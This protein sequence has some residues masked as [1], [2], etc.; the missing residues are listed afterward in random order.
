MIEFA[1]F[2]AGLTRIGSA[3]RQA[4]TP[5]D[6]E[7]YHIGMQHHADA[8]EWDRF[9]R[10]AIDPCRWTFFPKLRELQDALREF[11]G[12]RPMLAE[13]TNAYERVLAAGVYA[14]EGGTSWSYRSVRET[15]GD[16]AAEAF[17]AAGGHNA[18]AT[19]WEESKRRER[20][21]NAYADAVREEPD[22]KLLP[23]AP[24]RALLPAA[25]PPTKVEAASVIERLREM[26][27]ADPPKPKS[28]VVTVTDERM[29]ALRRQA[30][31][32]QG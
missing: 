30:Q 24:A 14:Q 11:R 8:A 4:P 22:A 27:Q 23:P 6:F 21:V 3:C 26:V 12:D 29:E 20:F 1:A 28:N 5:L 17:L 25:E 9:T 7:V 18:F 13:A 16:A 19:T 10:W 2:V 32:I 31:E 15:C